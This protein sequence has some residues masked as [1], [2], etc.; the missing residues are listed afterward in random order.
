MDNE[1]FQSI[2]SETLNELNT[3][4]NQ[5]NQ[6]L[7]GTAN[8]DYQENVQTDTV[9]D[10]SDNVQESSDE[11]VNSLKDN[12]ESEN[13]DDVD[14]ANIL[15]LEQDEDTP[16]T[17]EKDVQAFARM[18]TELKEANNNLNA[19]K[20]VI[21]F[22]DVR[23]R[24]MGLD[25]IKD[26]MEKTVEAETKKQAEKQGIPV[27]VLKRINTL[28]DKVKQ[29]DIERENIIRSQKE[30]DINYVLDDFVQNHSLN[31]KAINK[32]AND[33]L[34]DGFNLNV[35]MNMPR[36]AVNRILNSYLP[37]ETVS[38]DILAKKEQIKKEVPPT[39][40]SSSGSNVDDKI[41]EIAKKWL[42]GINY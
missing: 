38:Q 3:N 19:A 30:K 16:S 6:E 33:L 5:D 41:D 36:S 24:Q 32:M 10:A 11:D 15:D 4:D 13:V 2:V 8:S 28:E 34:S 35:L 37:K 1:T 23:A 42:E 25:G 27:D 12:Q 31:Q 29:Q 26:L 40:N 9:E 22:F 14:D 17:N 7:E 18:R 20:S 21:D 39:G